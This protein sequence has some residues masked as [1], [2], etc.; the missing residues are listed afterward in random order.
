M[1]YGRAFLFHINTIMYSFQSHNY[2]A[3]IKSCF[4]NRLCCDRDDN[5]KRVITYMLGQGY[6]AYILHQDGQ[7]DVVSI[8][9]FNIFN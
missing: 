5:P 7:A 1:F 8:I 9:R 4:T 6:A 3:R 2:P